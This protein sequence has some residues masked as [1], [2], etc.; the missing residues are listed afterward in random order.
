MPQTAGPRSPQTTVCP[1]HTTGPLPKPQRASPTYHR[2]H[3]PPTCLS[4]THRPQGLGHPPTMRM[5]APYIYVLYMY[6]VYT[7]IGRLV[8][9]CMHAYR[10]ASRCACAYVSICMHARTHTHACVRACMHAYRHECTHEYT[11]THPHT[12]MRIHECSCIYR[13]VCMCK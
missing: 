13:C 2:A 6:Y 3:H 7:H 8:Y 12:S 5:R 9:V 11:R 4:P 1:H 10:F